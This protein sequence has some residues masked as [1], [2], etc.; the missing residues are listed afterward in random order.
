MECCMSLVKV[1]VAGVYIRAQFCSLWWAR[2][3]CERWS[4]SGASGSP[5]PFIVGDPTTLHKSKLSDAV[6]SSPV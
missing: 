6:Q 1:P 3:G 5:E 2:P 4:T